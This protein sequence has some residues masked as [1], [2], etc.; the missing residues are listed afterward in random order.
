M[1]TNLLNWSLN[2]AAAVALTASLNAADDFIRYVARPGATV[3][4]NGTSSIHDWEVEG[5][6]VGGYFKVEPEFATDLSLKSVPSV[7]T[8]EKNPE[9]IISIPIRSL[10]SGKD[11]MDRIMQEAMKAEENPMIK[12]TLKEMIVKGDVPAEGSPVKFD[13][14]GDL[15]V[16]GETKPVELVLTMERKPNKMLVFKGEQK[17]KMTD[18]GITPPAPK[19]PGMDMIKTGDDV[20]IKFE[21]PVQTR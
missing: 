15:A 11:A 3:T 6:I 1:K 18:F 17:L 20:T 19:I 7:T 8:K 4:I 9:A 21:W 14:K 13:A 10:K 2:L 5:K 16:S 12:F